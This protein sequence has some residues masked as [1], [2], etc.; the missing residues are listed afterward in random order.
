MQEFKF[1]T[2][3]I[4][5]V[6]VS[7]LFADIPFIEDDETGKSVFF[8][9][10]GHPLIE[11]GDTCACINYQQYEIR[12]FQHGSCSAQRIFLDTYNFAAFSDP[13]SI[14]KSNL[15][16]IMFYRLVDGVDRRTCYV[17]DNRTLLSQKSIK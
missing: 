7:L 16:S 8:N 2:N 6:F 13:R 10:T 3:I 9:Q 15:V 17:T 14:D 12:F 4:D 1:I 11:L 5:G